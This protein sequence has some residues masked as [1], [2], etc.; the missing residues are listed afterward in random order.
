VF[1]KK[2]LYM[3]VSNSITWYS[4]DA[5]ELRDM[6]CKGLLLLYTGEV[7]STARVKYGVIEPYRIAGIAFAPISSIKTDFLVGLFTA[8]APQPESDELPFRWD[9]VPAGYNYVTIDAGDM[10]MFCHKNKPTHSQDQ[11]A[12]IGDEFS[13][14][15][16]LTGDPVSV[17]RFFVR[18]GF[19][20]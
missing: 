2:A 8:P 14:Q 19:E 12:Y 9:M 3:K 15:I 7:V 5:P 4:F 17:A 16:G 13:D 11:M 6:N 1:T 18:P 20:K 10:A